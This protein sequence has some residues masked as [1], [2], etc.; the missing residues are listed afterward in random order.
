MRA[1]PSANTWRTLDIVVVAVL[2]V[3][4]GVIFWGMDALWGVLNSAFTAVPPLKAFP[5]G[6]WLLPAVLGGLIIRKPGAAVL[7]E[8]I[9]AT[10]SAL[11]G[12]QWGTTVI[13]QG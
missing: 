5:Y 12:N 6:V 2:A 9:A 4:F 13:W 10:V 8:L 11:L 1:T 7:C 3:A